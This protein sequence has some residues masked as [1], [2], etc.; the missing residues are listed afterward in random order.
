VKFEYTEAITPELV[1]LLEQTTL[2][3]NGAMYRHLDVPERIYQTDSPLCFSLRRNDHLLANITFCKRDFGLYL[4]YFAF[5]K[6][7]QSKGK[8]R[9][10]IQKSTLKQE[11]EEVFK[12]VSK[13]HP[14]TMNMCYAFIDARNA[15]SKW[16]SEQFGFQTKA[17]LATQTFSRRFPKKSMRISKEVLTQEHLSLIKSKY[18]QY[19]AYF[20]HYLHQG[21]LHCLRSAEGTLLALAKFTNVT[22]EI[23]RLPGKMGGFLVKALPF[24]PVLRKMIQPKK[25]QFLVPEAMCILENNAALLTEFLSGVLYMQERHTM[26]WWTD[27]RDDLYGQVKNK[28]NWGI[29]HQILGVSPVDVVVRGAFEPKEPIYVA[30]FDMI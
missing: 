16:M 25:H 13:E 12:N 10:T 15:R 8:A 24:I 14:G 4:R 19:T 2:G 17:K 6:R 27:E 29:L 3:T 23:S 11:I 22:W 20:D 1:Q 18:E 5:D 7:F 9:Q 28:V 21:E 26:L 30:A